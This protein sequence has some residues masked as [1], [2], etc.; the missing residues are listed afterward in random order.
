MNWLKDMAMLFGEWVLWMIIPLL[1][2]ILIGWL[3]WHKSDKVEKS[4]K[5]DLTQI[6]DIT[7]DMEAKLN[8]EGI[9]TYK[10][11]AMISKRK[12]KELSA[13]LKIDEARI[14]DENWAPQAAQLHFETYGES[15]YEKVKIKAV[16]KDA[17]EAQMAEAKK[18]MKLDYIDDLKLVSGVGPKME[19]ILHEYG[20]TTFYHLSK[21]NKDGV[22]ALNEKLEFFHG[23]IERDDWVGQAK[24]LHKKLRK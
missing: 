12:M 21:L 3:L 22:E 23:R 18:G 5:D 13:T 24:E 8:G 20:I 15:I 19:K 11:M 1:I 6:K 10:D 9:H 14:K 7:K 4:K 17:F 16:Y 2:G